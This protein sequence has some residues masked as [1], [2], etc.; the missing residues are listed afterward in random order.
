M[1]TRRGGEEARGVG[2]K[3]SGRSGRG[4]WMGGCGRGDWCVKEVTE[5]KEYNG[6]DTR[7]TRVGF[8]RWV[9]GKGRQLCKGG[10]EEGGI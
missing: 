1:A 4:S 10:D 8:G 5:R 9:G 7:D 3:G 2:I 6:K